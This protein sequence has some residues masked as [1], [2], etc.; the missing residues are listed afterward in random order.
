M[1][2]SNV[3]SCDRHTLDSLSSLVKLCRPELG[4]SD[5]SQRQNSR[6]RNDD[7][8][9]LERRLGTEQWVLVW[10]GTLRILEV[11]RIMSEMGKY[12]CT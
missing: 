11:P 6:V 1:M 2:P 9:P 12:L 7:G 3:C 5:S 8:R 10:I 4:G